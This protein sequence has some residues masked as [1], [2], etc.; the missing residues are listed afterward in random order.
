MLICPCRHEHLYKKVERNL[1]RTDSLP[2]DVLAAQRLLLGSRVILS[3]LSNL[4]NTKMANITRVAPVKNLVVDEASQVDVGDYL[5]VINRFQHNLEKIVF[6]GDDK[7]RMSSFALCP[8][9]S[10]D[11]ASTVAPYGCDQIKQLES[12]F[13]KNHLRT[14]AVMLDTQCEC[15]APLIGASSNVNLRSYASAHRQLHLDTR[16]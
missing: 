15:L 13:E 9:L 7:Q 3:T 8:D 12:I 16:L 2:D 5:P 1:I 6:I 14:N 11:R 4:L 10:A